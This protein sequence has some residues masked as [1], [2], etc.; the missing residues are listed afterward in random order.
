M[1]AVAWT[2]PTCATAN[3]SQ[4]CPTCGERSLD[5]RELTLR[6]L[7]TQIFHALTSVDGRLIRTFVRLLRHPGDLTVAYLQGQ[8]KAYIGPVPLYFMANVVFFAVESLLGANIFST[9]LDYHLNRQ[10]WDS[11][12]RT[13]VSRHLETHGLALE[14]YAPV[15]DSAL[16]LHAHSLVILMALAFAALPWVVFYGRHKPFV[17]HAVFS[18][19]LYAFFL[20]LLCVADVAPALDAHFGGGEA[21]WQLV[22]NVLAVLSLLVC[23]AYLYVATKKVYDTRGAARVAQ[24]AVLTLGVG[25]IVL[26]YRF[27][28]FLLTFYTAG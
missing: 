23:A 6:G 17:V 3:V 12:A 10:P 2:C 19:H 28:L 14:A 22:D 27:A 1:T 7:A 18:L 16:R 13:L 20:L 9:S 26:G 11:W 4:F 25:A 24:V 21:T 8:R 15:F 5:E